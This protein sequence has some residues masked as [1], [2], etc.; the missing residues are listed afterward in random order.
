[1]LHKVPGYRREGS[2]VNEVEAAEVAALMAA[3]CQHPAYAHCTIGAISLLGEDQARAIY[4][5][6]VRLVPEEELDRRSFVCGDAYH[7]QG[8]ERD[9]MFL[10]LVETGD[11]RMAT[12]NRLPDVQR[13]NVAASRP[14][15]QL[16]IVHS[17][18]AS[19]FHP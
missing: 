6:V 17:V 13:F 1:V 7:F 12:L 16:W 19:A 9:V 2:K 10:S 11:G 15:D 8:D 5:R 18:D 14:K 3:V 4:E